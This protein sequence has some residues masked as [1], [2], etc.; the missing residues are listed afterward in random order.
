VSEPLDLDWI[1]AT[2][3]Q[4]SASGHDCP[5]LGEAISRWSQ[6]RFRVA[7][8]SHS[9]PS[10]Q[11]ALNQAGRRV[12][13]RLRQI[14]GHNETTIAHCHFNA[15]GEQALQELFVASRRSKLAR[16]SPS[17]QPLKC[18]S[19]VGSDHGHGVIGRMA[20]GRSESRDPQWPLVPGFD[21][22]PWPE[23][24]RRID[25]ATAMV[26]IAPID[27]NDIAARADSKALNAIRAACDEYGAS[28]VID[29]REFAPMGGGFF[30]IHD[31]I[32]ELL[33]DAVMM[34]SGLCGA[35]ESGLVVSGSS[36][37]EAMSQLPLDRP[38][39]A[40]REMVAC[41][42]EESLE[43]WLS[44]DLLATDTEDFAVA[45]AGRLS[46]YESIRDLHVTGRVIG[47]ETDVP[48]ADWMAVAQSCRLKVHAAGEFAVGLQPPLVMNATESS[49]LIDR[50][51]MVFDKILATESGTEADQ[52]EADQ[53]QVFTEDEASYPTPPI[54]DIQ[55][56]T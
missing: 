9:A 56:E 34:S 11:S 36:L 35:M 16:S 48:S 13:E 24:A 49:D 3:G 15:T 41:M 38:S 1:D 28:L 4:Y 54:E 44:S 43:R 52:A 31:S 8:P 29:H 51:V 46:A 2:A 50:V 7:P 53:E 6:S 33:A 22:V 45:L 27:R 55:A 21:H 30:W 47:I 20:S 40:G 23:L 19:T 12:A 26:L 37:A 32:T 14:T 17:S 10:D 39:I 25:S 42:I 5:E 18:L